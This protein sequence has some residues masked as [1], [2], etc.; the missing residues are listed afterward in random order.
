M[1]QLIIRGIKVKF[2][3]Y[4]FFVFVV[5]LGCSPSEKNDQSI[6]VIE[7]SLPALANDVLTG[8]LLYEQKT[9]KI[10][11]VVG[12]EFSEHRNNIEIKVPVRNVYLSIYPDELKQ[13]DLGKY[14]RGQAYT[15][16]VY[17]RK[18]EEGMSAA[19]ELDKTIRCTLVE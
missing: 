11:A 2:F 9:V 19:L 1:T 18:I 6:Q 12:Y 5:V 14:K 3:A 17:I 15:F 4:V 7:I 13:Q 8:S 16:T 10:R